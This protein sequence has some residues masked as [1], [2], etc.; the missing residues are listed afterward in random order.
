MKNKQKN[1]VD[2]FKKEEINLAKYQTVIMASVV[3]STSERR[4]KPQTSPKKEV[5]VNGF[6]RLLH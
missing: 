1:V 2:T 3:C 5:L 4:K 6:I